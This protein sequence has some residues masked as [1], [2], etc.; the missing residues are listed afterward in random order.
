M[1]AKVHISNENYKYLQNVLLVLG[2]LICENKNFWVNER[3]SCNV[4]RS[5]FYK[6]IKKVAK[7]LALLPLCTSLGI[8]T[9]DPLIK[10][11]LVY[12]PS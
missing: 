1:F 7:P 5:S 3:I 2:L 4:A 9:L 6:Q 10:S 12:Q 8:R 11:Q